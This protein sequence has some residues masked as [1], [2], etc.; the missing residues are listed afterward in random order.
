MALGQ[1][2]PKP[3]AT[4][5]RWREYPAT[6][7]TYATGQPAARACG[8]FLQVTRC[9][10]RPR[11]LVMPLPALLQAIA[12]LVVACGNVVKVEREWYAERRRIMSCSTC[13]R[14][15]T[16]RSRAQCVTPA[17][18]QRWSKYCGTATTSGKHLETGVM[19]IEKENT[20]GNDDWTSSTAL[21][22]TR[23]RLS[24]HPRLP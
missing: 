11:L 5:H 16:A 10:K 15:T 18:G 22:A 20:Q 6:S 19:D 12:E 24:L 13:E 7:A 17:F 14:E 2:R 1:P 9:A 3:R 4:G 8:D 23:I 21:L